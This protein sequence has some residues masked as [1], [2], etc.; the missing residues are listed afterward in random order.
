MAAAGMLFAPVLVLLLFSGLGSPMPGGLSHMDIHSA[1]AQ[2]AARF[3][4]ESY[5][6]GSNAIH[7]S[8]IAHVISVK[9]QVVQGMMYQV[10]MQL[11]KTT[12]RKSAERNV[13]LERCSF[14][15]GLQASKM[16]VCTFE[17]WDRPWVPER[18]VSN[19][20]CVL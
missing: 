14:Q 3:A 4:I 10:K 20:Q 15:P 1:E 19:M 7:L 8:K 11:G 2:E 18:Q 5:N 16:Q 9:S 6:R 13:D 17:I 12:C